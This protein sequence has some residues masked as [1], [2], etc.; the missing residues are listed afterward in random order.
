MA[1]STK[2]EHIKP[3]TSKRVTRAQAY[4]TAKHN[5]LAGYRSLE[6]FAISED[7]I[8]EADY[9]GTMYH[10]NVI[11]I[12][13]ADALWGENI[14]IGISVLDEMVFQQ[15]TSS[16]SD[17]VSGVL[18]ELET[19]SA[20][21]E[22][23]VIYPLHGLGMEIPRLLRKEPERKPYAVFKESGVAITAQVHSAD[24][25]YERICLLLRKLDVSDKVDAFD[26]SHYATHLHWLTRNPLMI[27]RVASHTGSYYE[28]QFIYTLK[29]RLRSALIAMIEA[30]SVARNHIIAKY[31]S[32]SS[33]NNFET[34]DI[35]HYLVGEAPIG[36]RKI[37]ELRRVPM[38]LR[39]LELALLSD[40]PVS[41]ASRTLR[42]PA[43]ATVSRKATHAIEFIEQGHLKHVNLGKGSS[44]NQRLYARIVTALDWF[45]R[46]TSAR[47]TDAESVVCLAVAFETLLT[48]QYAPGVSARIVRRARILMKGRHGIIQ[49]LQAIEALYHARSAIVHSGSAAKKDD[50][51]EA[52]AA[53]VH[54][55]IRLVA[56]IER[57]R[58][59]DIQN[60]QELLGD[61]SEQTSN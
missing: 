24:A 45:R 49:S 34:L 11:R 10:L 23:F 25:A 29:I 21:N 52:R 46:S 4:L 14:F 9:R 40:L 18:K 37:V 48:D 55:F 39:P 12:A 42:L 13:L 50:M 19:L 15:A 44:A 61:K 32:S 47:I 31:E 54:C 30:V 1:R 17:I 51:I 22:G 27:V 20:S 57:T 35:R 2:L 26:L 5:L 56:T 43:I 41:I 59:A 3:P 38:N 58:P 36:S 28:N 60:I 53:F 8:P 6:E 33:V 16:G 7:S